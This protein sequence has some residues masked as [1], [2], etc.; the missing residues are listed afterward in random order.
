MKV[1]IDSMLINQRQKDDEL[2]SLE[3]YHRQGIITIVGAQ[4]LL[5][6]M[7]NRNPVSLAKAK[8]Y[9]NISEPFTIGL[10][11]IGDAYISGQENAPTFN[12]LSSILFP[13]ISASDLTE[14]QENDVMHLVAHMHS[15]SQCFI[16][17]NTKDFI[18]E[19]RTNENR[20]RDLSNLKRNKL[21][22]LGAII[23][24]PTELLATLSDEQII[25][26]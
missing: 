8:Q 10:S 20:N 22:E 13:E 18:D 2:N 16:T 26:G 3:E 12:Q 14:N 24:T 23:L 21:R 17:R 11:R 9:D 1:T 15:D 7:E 5:Y 19:K 4:R 6:E 25:T